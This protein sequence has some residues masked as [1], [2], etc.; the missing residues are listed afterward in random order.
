MRTATPQLPAH[1]CGALKD[2]KYSHKAITRRRLGVPMP[3]CSSHHQVHTPLVALQKSPAAQN[4][5][6]CRHLSIYF[7]QPSNHRVPDSRWGSLEKFVEGQRNVV[8]VAEPYHGPTCPDDT[9]SYESILEQ[10]RVLTAPLSSS[11]AAIRAR[12]LQCGCERSDV[13]LHVPPVTNHL[14]ARVLLPAAGCSGIRE[15]GQHPDHPALDH[16]SSH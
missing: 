13:P 4:R 2:M 9:S 1:T 3:R 16:S 11:C 14:D 8:G 7:I 10:T 12:Q 15:G 5:R 6:H